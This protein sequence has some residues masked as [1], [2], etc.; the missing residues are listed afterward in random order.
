MADGRY[1]EK[2]NKRPYLRNGLTD[3]HETWH[4]GTNWHCKAYLQ[5]EFHTSENPLPSPFLHPF[6]LSLPSSFFQFTPIPSQPFSFFSLPFLTL[7]SSPSS[8]P[9]PY[10]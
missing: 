1:L 8:P 6:V 10:K 9:F 3:L 5:L 4:G 7:S 2:F